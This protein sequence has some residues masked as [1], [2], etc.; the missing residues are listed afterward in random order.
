MIALIKEIRTYLNYPQLVHI[1]K[2]VDHPALLLFRLMLICLFLGIS[3]GIFGGLLVNSGLI[4]PPGPSVLESNS[5]PEYMLLLG[6]IV[7]GP[8]FEE[9]IFRAQL[10]RFTGNIVFISTIAG[11]L[12][13]AVIKSY[14][15]F[16]ISPVL[17]SILF[18]IYRVTVPGS[19]GRKFRF[20]NAIF[21]WHFHFTAICFAL[22]HLQ[23]FEKGIALLPLGILYTLPQLAAGLVLGFTRMNYGLKY[24]I[25]LHALYNLLPAL[26]LFSKY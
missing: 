11:V 6:P 22:M 4:P 15:G 8:L 24:S 16:L 9:L 17:F 19:V 1:P 14:W 26:L 3:A 10:R 23:N 25:V 7:L 12:I 2:K 21:P 18:I 20:W 13:S 5:Y